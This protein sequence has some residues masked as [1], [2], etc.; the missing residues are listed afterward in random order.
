MVKI[1]SFTQKSIEF[2]EAKN[3]SS[4]QVADAI[5]KSGHIPLCKPIN[6]KQR[7]VGLAYCCFAAN[8]SNQQLQSELPFIPKNAVVVV[9]VHNI[10]E[11]AIFGEL[12][13]S[14]IFQ[15]KNAKG[16]VVHG[17]LR[18]APELL[19][20]KFPI[21]GY[22]FSP[23]GVSNKYS[24]EFPSDLRAELIDKYQNSIIVAD[25]S[26]VVA[27]PQSLVGPDL[28]TKLESIWMREIV[29]KYCLEELNWNPPDVIVDRIYET[30]Y[31]QLPKQL[32][33]YVKKLTL[34]RYLLP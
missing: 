10:P 18:D 23:I 33:E 34:N 17:N 30:K 15:K 27:I 3:L 28:L 9:F 16:I 31:Q 13:A 19:E 29:W 11:N 7:V 25:S 26:G 8:G 22:G 12:V 5:N 24:I 14:Y 32:Q 1:D 20:R 2:I 4:T 6:Q 21:W